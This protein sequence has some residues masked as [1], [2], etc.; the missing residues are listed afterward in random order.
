M[1][2]GSP[3]WDYDT[4]GYENALMNLAGVQRKQSQTSFPD[5]LKMIASMLLDVKERKRLQEQVEWERSTK[6]RELSLESMIGEA[7]ADYY[8]AQAEDARRVPEPKTFTPSSE[9]EW[10]LQQNPGK[11]IKDYWIEKLSIENQHEKPDEPT[12]EARNWEMDIE[13]FR[14]KLLQEQEGSFGPPSPTGSS[15]LLSKDQIA[16]R[17]WNKAFERK[18]GEKEDESKPKITVKELI[19]KM[20]PTNLVGTPVEMT[21]EL[22][23]QKLAPFEGLDEATGEEVDVAYESVGMPTRAMRQQLLADLKAGTW[24][25][26]EGAVSQLMTVLGYDE[27]TA[28]W[29][30]K[31]SGLTEK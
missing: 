6:E 13:N 8:R 18:Y 1:P 27:Q 19:N 23:Y 24:G 16:K 20:Q 5:F 7:Q 10:W 14:R 22:K 17:A 29:L 21:P 12:A 4:S 31:M 30:V 15:G 25:D 3:G 11:T 2:L 26:A 9:L 28:K